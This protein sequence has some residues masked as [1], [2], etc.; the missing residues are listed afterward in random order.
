[1]SL[2]HQSIKIRPVCQGS[3]DLLHITQT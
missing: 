3:S 1:V 2:G